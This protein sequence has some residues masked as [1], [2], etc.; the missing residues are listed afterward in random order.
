MQRSAEDVRREIETTRE[1]LE[2]ALVALQ[3]NISEATDWK[4]WVR[5]RP[6]AVCGIAF[7]LGI[8]LGYR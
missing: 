6:A 7:G 1:D 4:T 5:R 2:R 8:F 3:S